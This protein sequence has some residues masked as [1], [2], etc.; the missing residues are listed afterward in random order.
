MILWMAN[1][2][3]GSHSLT[4]AFIRRLCLAPPSRRRSHDV[5]EFAQNSRPRL[6]SGQSRT[7]VA[8]HGGPGHHPG[9][10]GAIAA[11]PVW[12][13]RFLFG[14]RRASVA[15]PCA[16]PAAELPPRICPDVAALS[17]YFL[18]GV[19]ART[20]GLSCHHRG[21]AQYGTRAFG[22]CREIAVARNGGAGAEYRERLGSVGSFLWGRYGAYL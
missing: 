18:E 12:R 20:G 7:R 6:A 5:L 21:A 15:T 3:F 19:T 11:D 1:H 4:P 8:E 10:A 9:L 16:G 22:G 13:Q 17:G 2:C 14:M